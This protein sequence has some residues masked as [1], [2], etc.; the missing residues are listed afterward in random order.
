MI[1]PLQRPQRL[2]LDI[3]PGQ[4]DLY[5]VVLSGGKL[6]VVERAVCPGALRRAVEPV[7]HALQRPFYGVRLSAR[8]QHQVV[9]TD[10]PRDLIARFFKQFAVG[11]RAHHRLRPVHAGAFAP[12]LAD[13]HQRDG[14]NVSVSFENDLFHRASL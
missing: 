4:R 13:R 14:I 5:E 2:L 1:S 7:F 10:V 12:L 3:F 6:G 8:S 11:A 9:R